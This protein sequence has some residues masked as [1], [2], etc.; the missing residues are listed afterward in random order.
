VLVNEATRETE[1]RALRARVDVLYRALIDVE[2]ACA[3]LGY[4]RSSNVV[5]MLH[6]RWEELVLTIAAE[7]AR[8]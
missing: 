2:Q 7:E 6:A 1:R 3:T 8:A 5:G 4:A